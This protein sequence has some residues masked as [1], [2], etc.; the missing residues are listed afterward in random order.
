V[1]LDHWTK[2]E[3]Q[4]IE[5]AAQEAAEY[6]RINRGAWVQREKNYSEQVERCKQITGKVLN[7]LDIQTQPANAE[8]LGLLEGRHRER[9]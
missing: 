3:E 5:G 8:L 9:E 2:L 4:D 6:I 1:P 7:I